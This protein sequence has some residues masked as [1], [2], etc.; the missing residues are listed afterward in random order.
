L[1]FL[2]K[3]T[4]VVLQLEEGVSIIVCLP[5]LAP[6]VDARMDFSL[7]ELTTELVVNVSNEECMN[8]AYYLNFEFKSNWFLSFRSNYYTGIF[9]IL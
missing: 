8:I 9:V 5:S 6:S 7:V 3:Q 1:N 2:S 4:F